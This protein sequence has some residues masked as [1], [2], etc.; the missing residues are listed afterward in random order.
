MPLPRAWLVPI[1]VLAREPREAH[2]AQSTLPL[3]F[4]EALELAFALGVEATPLVTYTYSRFPERPAWPTIAR[5][6]NQGAG[7][8][9]YGT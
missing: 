5:A 4:L 1:S 2:G 3:I 6:A 7:R 9:A 8:R